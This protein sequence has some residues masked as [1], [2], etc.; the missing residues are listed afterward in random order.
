MGDSRAVLGTISDAEPL[1]PR[2]SREEN[3][4]LLQ[5]K[6]RRRSYLSREV[7]ELQLTRDHRPEDPEELSR[8]EHCGGKVKKYVDYEGNRVG[9][10]RVWESE[11]KV[12][13]LSMS[14]SL[15][16]RV[17]KGLGVIARPD[18]TVHTI[19]FDKDLF[20]IIGSDGIW[21]ALDNGDALKFVEMYRKKSCKLA[22]RPKE[23]AN[24][25]NSCISQLLC[26]EARMRWIAIVEEDN[27]HIDD[28]STIVLEFQTDGYAKARA[29]AQAKGKEGKSAKMGEGQELGK[30]K[31]K[32][33]ARLRDPRRGSQLEFIENVQYSNK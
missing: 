24:L 21:E 17:A 26:E 1:V 31:S 23:D 30:T 25:E 4:A 13:G 20:V 9:P 22:N 15:G 8:I 33:N 3:V 11:H 28:I 5:V 14:R 10:Y 27:V 6:Q 2:I 29:K 16:D 18:V 32:V 12:P 7:H 19:D